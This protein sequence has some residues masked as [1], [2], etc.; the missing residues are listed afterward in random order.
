MHQIRATAYISFFSVSHCDDSEFHCSTGKCIHSQ[1]VCD[2]EFDCGFNDFSDELECGEGTCS[3][4]RNFKCLSDNKCI[5]RTAYC[6]GKVDCDDGSDESNCRC[7]ADKFHCA[8]SK[9]VSREDKLCNGVQDCTFG[10]DEA[11]CESNCRDRVFCD[12]LCLSKSQICDRKIDCSTGEG[13][14]S[15]NILNGLAF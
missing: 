6:D 5:P 1:F 4:I 12:G 2:G 3:A 9:C 14:V 15:S 8:D 13:R 10:E 7:S 11:N